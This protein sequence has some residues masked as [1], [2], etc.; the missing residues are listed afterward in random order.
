MVVPGLGHTQLPQ[1]K[2]IG[3]VQ[4]SKVY[5]HR[6]SLLEHQ[7]LSHSCV[8]SGLYHICVVSG[9]YH[10]YTTETGYKASPA[11]NSFQFQN[12]LGYSRYF[13]I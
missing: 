6:K 7:P 2:S 3:R 11:S 12:I 1:G 10:I 5:C 13:D 9:L 4:A 8:V